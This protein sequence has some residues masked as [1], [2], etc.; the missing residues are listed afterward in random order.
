MAT[1][2]PDRERVIEDLVHH[3]VKGMRWGV[4]TKKVST[5][6]KATAQAI[7]KAG[8][9]AAAAKRSHDAKIESKKI[10]KADIKSRKQFANKSYKKISDAELKSRIQRLEQEKRYRELKADRHVVRGREV[11]RQILES[12]LTKAGTYAANKVM[13]SAFDS[14]FEGSSHKDVKEKVKKAAKKAKEAADAVEVVAA[15][16][17][18][19]ANDFKKP[20]QPATNAVGGKATP[21][22][23]GKKPSYSQTKPSGKPKRRPRNPGSPLK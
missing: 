4:I 16:V 15:E 20:E 12:S 8:A 22:Q 6:S 10:K 7:K 23:I 17:H 21:K 2:L 11:T 19:Q 1:D 14:A 3:G 9:K 13:R 18:K 5:G